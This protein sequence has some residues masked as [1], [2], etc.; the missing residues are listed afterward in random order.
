[1][2]DHDNNNT[3][4]N[5]PTAEGHQP[6]SVLSSEQRTKWFTRPYFTW[7]MVCFGIMA[8]LWLV[9]FF[10]NSKQV[11]VEEL[12]AE[13]LQEQIKLLKKQI[14]NVEPAPGTT[15]NNIAGEAPLVSTL[16][17]ERDDLLLQ[18]TAMAKQRDIL[19]SQLMQKTS[20]RQL[21]LKLLAQAATAN[22]NKTELAKQQAQ[23]QQTLDNALADRQ[24]LLDER[25]Q[26]H[27]EVDHLLAERDALA[28]EIATLAIENKRALNYVAE[29]QATMAKDDQKLRR[30][31]QQLAALATERDK[32]QAHFSNA[33]Q[34][35]SHVAA[36]TIRHLQSDINTL[37]SQTDTAT[38][39]ITSIAEKLA[40]TPAN[41]LTTST[42]S[43]Q[44]AID[45]LAP[46]AA[47]LQATLLAKLDAILA[48]AEQQQQADKLIAK[49]AASAPMHMQNS[50]DPLQPKPTLQAQQLAQTTARLDL[51]Q[52]HFLAASASMTPNG[53]QQIKY[54]ADNFAQ[55]KIK[56]IRVFGYVDANGSASYDF[57]LAQRRASAVIKLLVRH[58]IPRDK[59]VL[60]DNNRQALPAALADNIE[61]LLACCIGLAT[62]Y[63]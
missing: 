12:K 41:S 20:E 39:L 35:L 36:P 28:P 19:T 42:D 32:L 22:R 37:R 48:A 45:W 61:E 1:M 31:Q 44:P 33:K 18:L 60:V 29:M 46:A 24:Q 47:P 8:A 16:R 55:G 17:A 56:N 50:P 43:K 11:S 2:N 10:T 13:L 6:R 62:T 59:I 30:H 27:L 53:R 54:A 26:L 58:G 15:A 3:T 4:V 25:D 57:S 23:L 34:D 51:R 7:I 52:I 14:S 5:S 38:A 40:I 21:A 9:L 63:N 49:Q